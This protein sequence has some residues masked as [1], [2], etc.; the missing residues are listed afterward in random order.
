MVKTEIKGC[1][2][3]CTFL[4]DGSRLCKILKMCNS[5]ALSAIPTSWVG[6]FSAYIDYFV[7][8]LVGFSFLIFGN[9]FWILK[10]NRE[11]ENPKEQQKNRISFQDASFSA[12]KLV[13]QWDI[14]LEDHY[15]K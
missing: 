2:F 1:G 4:E 5:N 3:G 15:R 11:G 8:S 6:G 10:P 9:S 14:W 12:N 7:F 13:C